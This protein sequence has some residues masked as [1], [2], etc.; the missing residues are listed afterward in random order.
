MVSKRILLL[1]F[2]LILC[3][4]GIVSA[5]RKL[6]RSE[7]LGIFDKLT[8]QPKNMWISAGTIEAVHDEY[9]AAK[10]TDQAK[11]NNQINQ[12]IQE[13]QNSLAKTELTEELQEMK[14]EAIPFNVRYELSNEYSMNSNVV[15]KYDGE[16]FSWEISVN[17]R[18]DSVVPGKE[19]KGNYMTEQFNMDWNSDRTFTWDGQKF[20]IYSPSTNQAVEDITDSFPHVVNGPL[21]AGIITW[22][23][24]SLTYDNLSASEAS[25]VEINMN[26]RM[27]VHLTVNSKDGTEMLFILEPQKDYAVLSCLFTGRDSIIAGQYGDFKLVSGNWVPMTILVEKYDDLADKPLTSDYWKFTNISGEVPAISSFN[28]NFKSNTIVSYHYSD[29]EPP[30]M[31]HYTDAVDVKQ[32]LDGGKAYLTSGTTALQNCATAALGY[33]A[34]QLKKDINGE[35]LSKL[36]VGK[37]KATSLY[38]MKQFAQNLGLYCRVV[39]TDLNTLKNLSG[40][41]AILHIPGKNHFVLFDHVDD[42]YVWLMDLTSRE[43]F[44]C[45][46]ID[47]FNKAWTERTALL[48]A[49]EPIKLQND[50]VEIADAQLH[51]LIGAGGY[52]CTELIQEYNVIYCTQVCGV[53]DGYYEYY[54]NR[55]GCASAPSGTCTYN[56]YLRKV[57]SLCINKSDIPIYCTVTGEWTEYYMWACK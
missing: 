20:T 56:L 25:A 31:Y 2:S 34:G 50:S 22:G 52:K 37:N 21:T 32:L 7:I 46:D 4:N 41:R 48:I 1:S 27:E 15:L 26:G 6:E 35:Q 10:T 14:L 5:E 12:E 39:R 38:A 24:G 44:Y 16:R 45:I 33:V 9:R 43:F 29:T 55:Y 54:Y 53:C 49:D 23:Y 30:L 28:S 40:P 42:R 11:I 18:T 57:E 8:S 13:Y 51:K 47:L 3:A 19:L 36:V 17:S